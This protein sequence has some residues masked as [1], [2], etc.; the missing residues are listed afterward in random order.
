MGRSQ[1]NTTLLLQEFYKKEL[2]GGAI[3]VYLARENFYH[4]KHF[5]TSYF[6][7][8]LSVVGAFCASRFVATNNLKWAV[9]PYI[10][11]TAADALILANLYLVRR[12][13]KTKKLNYILFLFKLYTTL[14]FIY[15]LWIDSTSTFSNIVA[16]TA[17][18]GIIHALVSFPQDKMVDSFEITSL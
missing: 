7:A 11:D 2:I 8:F 12:L 4:K 15:L 16:Y 5:V 14:A 17:A 3:L 10:L 13:T 6:S 18:A 1:Q 9:Y